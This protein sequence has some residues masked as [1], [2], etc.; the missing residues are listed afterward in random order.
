MRHQGES[1]RAPT[2]VDIG[3]VVALL[4]QFGD[5]TDGVDPLQKRREL[6]RT[7]QRPVGPFPAGEIG[8]RGIDLV[9]G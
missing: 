8:Q 6:D 4:G 5:A 3:M 7:T 1:N 2:D 9:V